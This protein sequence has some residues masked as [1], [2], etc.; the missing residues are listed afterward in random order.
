[1]RLVMQGS[2]SEVVWQGICG[3]VKLLGLFQSR[4]ENAA[5][6]ANPND[7]GLPSLCQAVHTSS[8]GTKNLVKPDGSLGKQQ[9]GFLFRHHPIQG[10]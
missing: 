9:I 7:P 6:K 4:E 3:Y 10:R 5:S 8:L 2:V 1:M